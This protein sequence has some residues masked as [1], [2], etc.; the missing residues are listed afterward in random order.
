MKTKGKR[1]KGKR[2][3]LK[4][5]ESFDQNSIV[6]PAVTQAGHSYMAGFKNYPARQSPIKKQW[7]FEKDKQTDMDIIGHI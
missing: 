5:Q 3:V 7:L 2:K 6:R 1:N 4:K